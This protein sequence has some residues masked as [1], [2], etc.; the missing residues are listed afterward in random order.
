[1]ADFCSRC[2]SSGN[3]DIDLLEIAL[4]L[5]LGHSANFLCEGCVAVAIYKD[6]KGFIY[7]V[8][9]VGQEYKPELVSFEELQNWER[10]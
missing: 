10:T 5:E 3:W 1:M 7:L 4:N 9:K 2:E 6:D 8:R